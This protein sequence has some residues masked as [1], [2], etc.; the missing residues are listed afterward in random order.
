MFLLPELKAEAKFGRKFYEM[1]FLG[2]LAEAC[3][4]A[5]KLP[6]SIWMVYRFLIQIWVLGYQ[7]DLA[8]HNSV[9]WWNDEFES[10]SL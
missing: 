1:Q 3:S 10:K 5:L 8:L 7:I 4:S 2:S 6:S 9:F